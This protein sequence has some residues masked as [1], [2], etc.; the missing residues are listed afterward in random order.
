MD[1]WKKSVLQFSHKFNPMI[2]KYDSANK[3]FV[4]N[5]KLGEVFKQKNVLVVYPYPCN[6]NFI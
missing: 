5:L 4:G 2:V 6:I 1:L 3:K